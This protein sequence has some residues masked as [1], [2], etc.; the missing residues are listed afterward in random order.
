MRDLLIDAAERAV[1][2][3]ESLD[4]RPVAPSAAAIEGLAALGGDLPDAPT[5]P[6]EVLRLL[7]EYGSPAAIASAG[8][9]FYGFVVGGSTPVA[10]AANWLATAWDQNAGLVVLGHGAAALERVSLGW[11]IDLLGLP[12]GTGGGFVTGATMANFSGLAAARHAVLAREG[13]DVEERGLFGAPEITVI[14]GGEV[15][16]SV[17]KALTML[18]LGRERVVSVPVDDQGRMIASA[19]PPISGPTIVCAQAGNVNTGAIDP[20]RE[21]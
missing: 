14:L 15:H 16:P 1:R 8:G 5:D 2:Y 7:D 21:I 4:E 19:I 10:V 6:A 18:G 13:W 11:L 12:P 3:R 9:R 17:S 20:L